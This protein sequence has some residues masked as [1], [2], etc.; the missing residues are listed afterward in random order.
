MTRRTANAIGDGPALRVGRQTVE[1]QRRPRGVHVL[2]GLLV[3]LAV[4]AIFGGGALLL[5]PSGGLL[6]MPVSL[7]EGSPFGTYLLPGAVLLVLFGLLP[8]VVV[9]GLRRRPAWAYLSTR[10]TNGFWLAA[11]G[12]GAALVV[13]ILVQMT[14]LRFFLQPILLLLGLV[15]VALGLLPSVRRY[16]AISGSEAG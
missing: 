16:Y 13:W 6:G 15:I 11:L 7:L 9:F 5:D 2:V 4:N 8:L 14:I 3:F 12:I 1:R 10:G